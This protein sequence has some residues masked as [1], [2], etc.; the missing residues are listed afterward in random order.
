MTLLLW[1]NCSF[2]RDH[3]QEW[4]NRS[5]LRVQ[6]TEHL[7]FL[8]YL[9]HMTARFNLFEYV[10]FLP[11]V[12]WLDPPRHASPCCLAHCFSSM[13]K[14]ISQTGLTSLKLG[15]ASWLQTFSWSVKNKELLKFYRQ[16]WVRKKEREKKRHQTLKHRL[17]HNVD[18]T[19]EQLG[20]NVTALH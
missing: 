15:N 16:L 6:T 14:F 12:V 18:L 3:F 4:M 17:I 10:A 7:S 5:F 8:F 11:L 13:R 20:N 1:I 19:L 2:L 9:E